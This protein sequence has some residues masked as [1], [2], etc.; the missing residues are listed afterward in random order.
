MRHLIILIAIFFTIVTNAQRLPLINTERVYDREI[1]Y[2]GE[3]GDCSVR[4]IATAY[5][6][7]YDDAYKITKGL[8]NR[9]HREGVKV[10]R[11]LQ[12]LF[13]YQIKGQKVLGYRTFD[14]QRKIKDIYEE[15]K[16]KG[17]NIFVIGTDHIF[18]I[19]D[20]KI[21]GNVDDWR[22]NKI[23]AVAFVGNNNIKGIPNIHIAK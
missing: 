14:S 12:V 6:I 13:R 15:Y 11:F 5:D 19:K 22:Y 8:M 23:I 17:N 7:S 10:V 4:A 16:D 3:D 21:Y 9:K 1:T 20:G 2:Y 18:N